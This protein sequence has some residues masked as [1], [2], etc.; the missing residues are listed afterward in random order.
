MHLFILGDRAQGM[1]VGHVLR[2]WDN[3]GV[4][5]FSLCIVR[6]LGIE[7][8]SSALVASAFLRP[9]LLALHFVGIRVQLVNSIPVT[10]Q[11][12]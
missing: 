8:G 12:A 7:L 10:Q 4:I 6:V 5:S 11:A 9:L 2:S 3:W 1:L